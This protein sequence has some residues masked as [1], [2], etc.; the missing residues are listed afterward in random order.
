MKPTP[1]ETSGPLYGGLFNFQNFCDIINYALGIRQVV[2]QWVLVP[3][4][5]GSNPSS[6]ARI[7]GIK[8]EVLALLFFMTMNYGAFERSEKAA[9]R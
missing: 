1:S 6:P 2:R 9:R 8:K 4:F 3:P 5:G 7:R